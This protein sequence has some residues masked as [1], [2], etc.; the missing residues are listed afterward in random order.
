MIPVRM[1]VASGLFAASAPRIALIPSVTSATLASAPLAGEHSKIVRPG[2][3]HDHLRMDIVQFTLLQ[4]TQNVL[5]RIP[6][7]PIF[8]AFHP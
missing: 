6:A 4:S 3:Q 7:R 8:P 1:I 5:N 2:H